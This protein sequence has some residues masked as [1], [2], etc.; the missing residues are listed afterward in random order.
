MAIGDPWDTSYNPKIRDLRNK[1]TGLP[2]WKPD[3]SDNTPQDDPLS[4]KKRKGG[5]FCTEGCGCV[6]TG[7]DNLAGGTCNLP[8][9]I[10]VTII[11]TP[12]GRYQA[13]AGIDSGEGE[14]FHLKFDRGV[15]RGSRCCSRN[16]YGDLLYACDPCKVTT[17]P[18]GAPSDCHYA[19]NKYKTLTSEGQ[20]DDSFPRRGPWDYDAAIGKK[21]TT[22]TVW[23]R[24]GTKS[25]MKPIVYGETLPT[26]EV[27]MYSDAKLEEV[28][29]YASEFSSNSQDARFNIKAKEKRILVGDE[30]YLVGH[31]I[32]NGTNPDPDISDIELVFSAQD[33]SE[34]GC[35]EDGSIPLKKR[36]WCRDSVSGARIQQ[37][38]YDT[39]HKSEEECAKA[40]E[41]WLYKSEQNCVFSGNCRTPEGEVL[42]QGC[43]TD[44]ATFLPDHRDQKSCEEAFHTWRYSTSTTCTRYYGH[45]LAKC[46]DP[47]GTDTEESSQEVC[48]EN[49]N[50]WYENTFSSNEWVDWEYERKSCCGDVIL[51]QSHPYH[52]PQIKGGAGEARKSATCFTPYSEVILTPSTVTGTTAPMSGAEGSQLS[53]TNQSDRSWFFGDQSSYWTL[54]VRPCNFWGACFEGGKNRPDPANLGDCKNEDNEIA[55][56][57]DGTEVEDPSSC[58]D[59][60]GTWIE[61][62]DNYYETTCGEEI[63]LFLPVDQFMN[64][65]DF[66]LT[67]SS[68]HVCKKDGKDV[69]VHTQYECEEEEEGHWI[70]KDSLRS[71][72][73]ESYTAWNPLMGNLHGNAAGDATLNGKWPVTASITS[74]YGFPGDAIERNQHEWWCAIHD[75]NWD[76]RA[77]DP[78][79]SLDDY[80][81]SCSKYVYWNGNQGNYY[82][83][84]LNRKGA[85][86]FYAFNIQPQ[87]FKATEEKQSR[88]KDMNAAG[89]D[90]KHWQ[91]CADHRIR[92]NGGGHW[93]WDYGPD[94]FF[95]YDFTAWNEIGSSGQPGTSIQTYVKNGIGS[96]SQTRDPYCELD[97][98]PAVAAHCPGRKQGS[99]NTSIA[100]GCWWTN[101]ES[102]DTA[103]ETEGDGTPITTESQCLSY[104]GGTCSDGSI[105]NKTD[106]EAAGATWTGD[107]YWQPAV[108][109]TTEE[110]CEDAA[111]RNNAPVTT[112]GGTW[113]EGAECTTPENC[114]ETLVGGGCD[115]TWVPE[116]DAIPCTSKGVCEDP[117]KC[118][119]K[120]IPEKICGREDCD[121]AIPD[122]CGGSWSAGVCEGISVKAQRWI[123]SHEGQLGRGSCNPPLY[124]GWIGQSSLEKKCPSCNEIKAKV[125]CGVIGHCL[126]TDDS[127]EQISEEECESKGRCYGPTDEVVRDKNG[128]PVSKEY[129]CSVGDPDTQKPI[130]NEFDCIA[131]GGEWEAACDSYNNTRFEKPTWTQCC[132]WEE[133]CSIDGSP[134]GIPAEV[135]I[136]YEE[137]QDTCTRNGVLIERADQDACEVDGGT[138][139]E[140]QD[141]TIPKTR[142]PKDKAECEKDK[143]YE[144][145]FDGGAEGIWWEQCVYTQAALNS[146]DDCP[147]IERIPDGLADIVLGDQIG[148]CILHKGTGKCKDKRPEG[149]E[150]VQIP[151]VPGYCD[152]SV[153]GGCSH[154]GPA[155]CNRT[156]VIDGLDTGESETESVYIAGYC[157]GA[158]PSHTCLCRKES[159]VEIVEVAD[160]AE[161]IAYA[162]DTPAPCPL[163]TTWIRAG[164]TCP[165]EASCTHSEICDSTW[166]EPVNCAESQAVCESSP[167]TDTIEPGS[168]DRINQSVWETERVCTDK[169][170]CESDYGS[171]GCSNIEGADPP[172]YAEWTEEIVCTNEANCETA[173]EFNGCGGIWVPPVSAVTCSTEE[174]CEKSIDSGG[175]G[176][177]WLEEYECQ[178]KAECEKVCRSEWVGRDKNFDDLEDA[179]ITP[180]TQ[181]ECGEEALKDE[182]V[183]W[184]DAK[185]NQLSPD[186][187]ADQIGSSDTKYPVRE[188]DIVKLRP[189]GPRTTNLPDVSAIKDGKAPGYYE[190]QFGL[191][192]N[193][194]LPAGKEV[195]HSLSYWHDTG[196][197]PR[198][199][200][201]SYVNDHCQGLTQHRRI[202]NATNERPVKITA[203]NHFLKDGDLVDIQGVM[204]NF[205]ANV[206]TTRDWMETQWEDKIYKKCK[207]D[208]CDEITWPNA[209]CPETT[210]CLDKDGQEIPDKD[211]LT[212]TD[213]KCDSKKPD[214]TACQN[215]DDCIAKVSPDEAQ[216][217]NGDCPDGFTKDPDKGPY[218]A[219]G[220]KNNNSGCGGKWTSGDG[221]IWTTFCDSEKFYAC[222]GVVLRGKEPPPAPFFVVKNPTVDTFEL[223]TC[224]KQPVDGR[225]QNAINLNLEDVAS[226]QKKSLEWYTLYAHM[227]D[228]SVAVGDEVEKGQQVGKVG[229]LGGEYTHLHF[230]V[231]EVSR[232][233]QPNDN[234][235]GGA[236]EGISIDTGLGV[237]KCRS[238]YLNEPREKAENVLTSAEIK[239]I[240]STLTL[241][242]DGSKNWRRPLNSYLHKEDGYYAEDYLIYPEGSCDFDR[243]LEEDTSRGEPVYVASG[244]EGVV[245]TVK[246]IVASEGAVIV[247][248]KLATDGQIG[249]PDDTPKVCSKNPGIPYE[250]IVESAKYTVYKDPDKNSGLPTVY[251]FIPKCVDVDGKSVSSIS[252]EEDCVDPNKWITEQNL[253]DNPDTKKVEGEAFCSNYGTCMIFEEPFGEE[254]SLLTKDECILLASTYHTFVPDGNNVSARQCQDGAGK[255]YITE[256]VTKSKEACEEKHSKCFQGENESDA[257]N[258]DQC[259]QIGGTWKK[260]VLTIRYNDCVE[261]TD[262]NNPN[263]EE[264]YIQA[265]WKSIADMDTS[266]S[267]NS[268]NTLGV[269]SVGVYRTC[270]FTGDL[271]LVNSRQ[272][273]GIEAGYVGHLG[274][275]ALD[276]MYRFGFG[277]PGYKWE[278][279]A[280]DYYVQIEQKGTC[281]ICCDHFM[282]EHLTAT[283]T[284]QSSSILNVI[285]CGFDECANGPRYNGWC[286]S[287]GSHPCDMKDLEACKKDLKKVQDGETEGNFGACLR[288][289]KP[290][291]FVGAHKRQPCQEAG[292]TFTPI[293][294]LEEYKDGKDIEDTCQMF[295]RKMIVHGTTNCRRCSDVY[296]SENKVPI[297]DKDS[298]LGPVGYDGESCCPGCECLYNAQDHRT[299][300]CTYPYPTCKEV[301]RCLTDQNKSCDGQ[302]AGTSVSVGNV[303]ATCTEYKTG[304]WPDM[305][306][307]KWEMEPCTCF[308][309]NVALECEGDTVYGDLPDASCEELDNRGGC[310]DSDGDLVNGKSKSEDGA[311]EQDCNRSRCTLTDTGETVDVPK[312]SS[313]KDKDGKS[314]SASNEDDCTTLISAGGACDSNQSPCTWTQ[315]CEGDDYTWIEVSAQDTET[316]FEGSS[317]C[318]FTKITTDADASCYDIPNS[319]AA[320]DETCPGLGSIS[321]SMKF[322]GVVWRSEWTLMNT[323]GTHQCDLGQHRFKWP[324]NCRHDGPGIVPSSE[325]VAINADCDACDMSQSGMAGRPINALADGG[326]PLKFREVKEPSIPQD[327]HFIRLVLGCGSSVPSILAYPDGDARAIQ[328]GF[329]QATD[330]RNNGLQ[331]WAEITNCT[332]TDFI[333][334]ET[335]RSDRSETGTKGAPPVY[336]RGCFSKRSVAGDW[337]RP[338]QDIS[339]SKTPARDQAREP[340][341][342]E[343]KF[344]F[345]GKCLDSSMSGPRGPCANVA[346]CTYNNRDK[347][348]HLDGPLWSG[349]VACSQGG[350]IKHKCSALGMDIYPE[351]PSENF[352]VYYVKDVNPKTGEGTLVVRAY[353]AGQQH[354]EH[355]YIESLG[356]GPGIDAL[357]GIGIAN[358]SEAEN[359]TF[360][361]YSRSNKSLNPY[362][363]AGGTKIT[364]CRTSITK[365]FY[366]SPKVEYTEHEGIPYG[367]NP[368]DENGDKGRGNGEFMEVKV[369]NVGALITKNPRKSRHL[370]IFDRSGAVNLADM[371]MLINLDMAQPYG[372]KPWPVDTQTHSTISSKWP[373]GMLMGPKNTESLRLDPATS[374]SQPG[375]VGPLPTMDNLNRMFRFREEAMGDGTT[376][377]IPEIQAVEPVAINE[378]HNVYDEESDKNG[379]C[380][381]ASLNGYSR[382]GI[383]VIYRCTIGNP[384]T[385]EAITDKTECTERGGEW[386]AI[387]PK[388]LCEEEGHIWIPNFLYTKAVTHYTNDIND[389]EKIV[390]SGSVTYPATCKGSRMGYCKGRLELNI[391]ECNEGKCIDTV[392]GENSKW[393]KDANGDVITNEAECS[394]ASLEKQQSEGGGVPE[395]AGQVGTEA[396][397]IPDLV[398]KKNGKWV[399]VFEDS[400]ADQY[401]CESVFKGSWVVGRRNDSQEGNGVYEDP[402]NLLPK[403]IEDEVKGFSEGCPVGCKLNGFF[404]EDPCDPPSDANPNGQC[405]EC[406]E[407]TEGPNK[408]NPDRDAEFR[409]PLG[410]ADGSYVARKRACQHSDY[411]NREDCE[412]AGWIWFGELS[413][414]EYEFALHGEMNPFSATHD[415][416]K[417]R[418]NLSQFKPTS[419]TSNKTKLDWI[420]D[421]S[422]VPHEMPKDEATCNQN[423]HLGWSWMKGGEESQINKAYRSRKLEYFKNDQN[424]YADW[425]QTYKEGRCVDATI[426]DQEFPEIFDYKTGVKDKTNEEIVEEGIATYHEI[427]SVEF[428]LSIGRMAGRTNRPLGEYTKC[429]NQSPYSY[430]ECIHL[431]N[432]GKPWWA[433]K[434]GETVVYQDSKELIQKIDCPS[435][436]IWIGENLHL[437]EEACNSLD[438]NIVYRGYPPNFAAELRAEAKIE[439]ISIVNDEKAELD[440]RVQIEAVG[441]IT[442]GGEA[443]LFPKG[444]VEAW[445]TLLKL[446]QSTLNASATVQGQGTVTRFGEAG[447][448]AVATV[449][450]IATGGTPSTSNSRLNA[451]S[452]I[453]AVGTG[454]TESTP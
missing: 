86:T 381:D 61:A 38:C 207:G 335:L 72:W 40:G 266:L 166:N 169:W 256:D 111:V 376:T 221:N 372:I 328:G 433:Y 174:I 77:D 80:H 8:P 414:K 44:D 37:R 65:S 356:S 135:I 34:V 333:G 205:G 170:K 194:R 371:D 367:N 224:D 159:S 15:W 316:W 19:N 320:V 150:K 100:E 119:S 124:V 378:F 323:V 151:E 58:E 85:D 122:G 70:K 229:D 271:M 309:N 403:K 117:A 363:P 369:A 182:Y 314:V 216:D 358:L 292:G 155:Y 419:R 390:I 412:E 31:S 78:G 280:N 211:P 133:G 290:L 447:M 206:M 223:F 430:G 429:L 81:K 181:D 204:G 36:P 257:K 248:H 423:S 325:L 383:S 41:S 281:P 108:T 393:I 297:R 109:C 192:R 368:A 57:E 237:P 145:P 178:S 49:G 380:T 226:S 160:E 127:F 437:T 420:Y 303:T 26:D 296:S 23:P 326:A 91:M 136:G 123:D 144:D 139:S 67:L 415:A 76:G 68:W 176:S 16:S 382:E 427:D 209:R 54:V 138:W 105:Y 391:N 276:D 235:G 200:L 29:L 116:V 88:A 311:T 387:S 3:D 259:E 405:L 434:S 196:L 247:E 445:G 60:G 353:P 142:P 379:Y 50:V 339:D 164:D 342:L 270:P 348:F 228:I 264:C 210:K 2:V 272:D 12:D 172:Q 90:Q 439:A 258:Q 140:G 273:V 448:N 161:C 319:A 300:G 201:S 141:T 189:A 93:F 401:I 441:Q 106:C 180:M 374:L 318:G 6:N 236:V 260:A 370:R 73:V 4:L 74:M 46:K 329:D 352:T 337:T 233:D 187:R 131:A 218:E 375:R 188:N 400:E 39:S 386:R 443:G 265:Q 149:C 395:T 227:T 190:T 137:G 421:L 203:R 435:S 118:N 208:S 343:R 357:V 315:G 425:L 278:D 255:V 301:I 396:R 446:G 304:T 279:R 35:L 51:D 398:F 282:P 232:L 361:S 452:T 11:R 179:S 345:A 13:R 43:Y 21:Q 14:T 313:C 263:F 69:Q 33:A 269:P 107:G 454:G 156:A 295:L 332:F 32:S 440:C 148:T 354:C 234:F 241:P 103:A 349:A 115:S 191:L 347:P 324:S 10:A 249:C 359:D 299:Y 428:F 98:K 399:Q 444:W 27:Q 62:K 28:V 327:G 307:Y 71:G 409:C 366:G 94:Y 394:F 360:G 64:C 362:L 9:E 213:G 330:Y 162:G 114:A 274:Q 250:T 212:C 238:T 225:I 253:K 110:T 275:D 346:C 129:S 341:P 24:R 222:D 132:Q 154:T 251:P 75:G 336:Q 436:S 97:E 125:E 128:Q 198:G 130:T 197:W 52:T 195:G 397:N 126:H 442:H 416:N 268:T 305:S 291:S 424:K 153:P 220:C 95:Y 364:G 293:M 134:E 59:V 48:E 410:P 408:E 120:W 294:K 89:E 231:A 22:D 288:S 83:E 167:C 252:A 350:D 377:P 152:R 449:K 298:F 438:E 7:A 147:P 453:S 47:N 244:G 254:K 284:G 184:R 402:D 143:V 422:E 230:A 45:E 66:N 183:V 431:N 240:Q 165:D 312:Y 42:Q 215:E 163:G 186:F 385:Q 177:T 101:G 286:C 168:G 185:G 157:D 287:D 310:R 63:V 30:G 389:G 113:T 407:V 413:D 82:N 392:L 388:D 331:L 351:K 262:I 373:K 432:E 112:C 193:Q 56:K 217:A 285:G 355:A 451:I 99:C 171:M 219:G 334:S 404:L 175:C 426:I 302:T 365:S 246:A 202:I 18:N 406:L 283:L 321:T 20:D 79:P 239:F 308:P 5:R 450:P 338:I 53:I 158:A 417:L 411:I 104:T 25:W 102:A 261:Q 146:I 242:L 84:L 245:S 384:D 121:K 306:H 317:G 340:S 289:D 243:A 173:V 267:G 418:S 92:W 1:R 17:L 322:D 344:T 87:P 96:C 277:G 55:K 199:E 214:G